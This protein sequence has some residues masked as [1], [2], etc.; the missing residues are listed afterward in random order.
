M[1][2]WSWTARGTASDGLEIQSIVF[3]PDAPELAKQLKVALKGYARAAIADGTR[4]DVTVKL[5]LIRLLSKQYDLFQKLKGDKSDGCT[6]ALATGAGGAPVP[7]GEVELTVLIDLAKD[8][9]PAKFMMDVSIFGADDED[10][11]AP[12]FKPDLYR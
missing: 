9:P 11:A 4:V 1:A 2:G 12:S 10:V 7:P 3:T 5:G 8:I 6:L